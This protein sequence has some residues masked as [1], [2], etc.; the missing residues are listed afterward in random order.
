MNSYRFATLRT[1]TERRIGLRMR[2]AL[3]FM[4]KLQFCFQMIFSYRFS[5]MAQMKFGTNDKLG[6]NTQIQRLNESDVWVVHAVIHKTQFS[7][8][9][10]SMYLYYFAEIK[11]IDCS[12]AV[13]SFRHRIST[14]L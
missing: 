11:E 6:T 13:R 9:F 5:S 4:S 3:H 10:I 7:F 12:C 2:C 8:L 14:M 1:A